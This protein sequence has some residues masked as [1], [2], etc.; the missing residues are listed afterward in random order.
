MDFKTA[1]KL[2]N[3]LS[4]EYAESFFK[5]LVDYRDISASEAASRLNI[6]ISTAQEFLEAMTSLGLVGK[7]EVYEG[8]RPYF[9]Y[10]LQTN[11]I[12][13]DIDLSSA[14][15]IQSSEEAAAKIRE[16]RNANAR[17]STARGG[18]SI[19]SIAVWTGTGRDRAERRINLTAAQGLF[20]YHLPFPDG[21]PLTVAEIM[22]NADVGEEFLPEIQDILEL[23][24]QFKVI[25]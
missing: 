12:T 17:F 9:R 4:K 23:L 14:R 5:L 8:K 7:K 16:A 2:G 6:H 18:R 11:R 15:R 20:L 21:E 22:K 10:S 3:Y 1:A 24:H 25:E 19:S 13:I